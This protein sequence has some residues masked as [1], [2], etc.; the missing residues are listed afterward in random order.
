MLLQFL[1]KESDLNKHFSKFLE[2][3]INSSSSILFLQGEVGAGKTT[4]I[5]LFLEYLGYGGAFQS[6]TFVF[7]RDYNFFSPV[8]KKELSIMHVD[9]YRVK[10]DA[11]L[12]KSFLE[13]TTDLKIVEWGEFAFNKEFMTNNNILHIKG[14]LK[15]AD[16][17]NIDEKYTA[18]L[19]SGGLRL[20]TLQT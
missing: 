3:I 15:S 8:L 9:F 17:I 2:L 6:P 4:F 19:E 14:F 1:S 13:T 20:Y 12:K 18:D 16:L 7:E 10:N 11:E 5:R